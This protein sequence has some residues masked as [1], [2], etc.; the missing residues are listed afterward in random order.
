[1]SSSVT[2]EESTA[3][4]GGAWR[5]ESEEAAPLCLRYDL[6][7][8][9]FS[10]GLGCTRC[11]PWGRWGGADQAG[12]KEARAGRWHSDQKAPFVPPSVAIY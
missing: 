4:I 5:G 9:M 6:V 11:L 10:E 7:S 1:M 2:R 3:A 8:I 12:V